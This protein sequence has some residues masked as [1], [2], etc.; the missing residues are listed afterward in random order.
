MACTASLFLSLKAA[1][2]SGCLERVFKKTM[3]FHILL[4][5]SLLHQ[6]GGSRSGVLPLDVVTI[7]N[8]SSALVWSAGKAEENDMAN[9]IGSCPVLS[10]K[11]MWEWGEAI[12]GHTF[13]TNIL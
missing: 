3:T 6:C 12:R 9:V 8:F 7:E 5:Y 11:P 2:S 1:F 4:D 13:I 10:Q